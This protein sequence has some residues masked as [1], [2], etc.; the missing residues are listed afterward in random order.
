MKLTIVKRVADLEKAL[1]QKKKRELP[2][3]VIISYDYQSSKWRVFETY[4]ELEDN[5]EILLDHYSQY[6]FRPNLK[7]RVLLDLFTLE[8]PDTNLYSFSS[9]EL[10]KGINK[11]SGVSLEYGGRDPDNPLNSVFNLTIHE[12]VKEKE[13][14]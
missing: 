6:I 14:A 13:G 5:R 4:P 3:L 10:F 8:E 7:A 12:P 11:K 1:T 9:E 2:T